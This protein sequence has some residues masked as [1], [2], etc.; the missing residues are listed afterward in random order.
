MDDLLS[1]VTAALRQR[2][3]EW[4]KIAEDLSGHVSYSWL[5]KVGA[6][7]Y[8]SDPTYKRLSIVR[9]YLLTGEVPGK[10]D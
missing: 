4:P 1:E 3:G 9:R 10:D 2:I 5:S 6:G 7:D 8:S